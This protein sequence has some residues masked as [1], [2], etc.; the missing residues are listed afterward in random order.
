M[1]PV[2]H[3]YDHLEDSEREWLRSSR[4]R[5]ARR[6]WL[7]IGL[8]VL[9]AIGLAWL[10]LDGP[11]GTKPRAGG[12]APLSADQRALTDGQA[13]LNA[14]GRFAVTD[15]L[16]VLRDTFWTNGPEYQLLARD[17]AKRSKPIGPPAY[18][19]T[20]SGTKVVAPTP[21]QRVLRGRVQVTRP[22]EVTQSYD[23]DIWLRRDDASGGR[24]RLWTI[25][26]TA[27]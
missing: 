26:R 17:A 22:G 3:R 11:P 10:T 4:Q 13:A 15:D 25:E 16:R 2:S 9:V 21:D 12:R 6:T 27:R 5:A 7:L 23:W 1:P 18:T 19:F 14:W 20:M 8:L 24:W